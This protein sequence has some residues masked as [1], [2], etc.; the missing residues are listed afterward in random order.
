[1]TPPNAV[2]RTNNYIGRSNWSALG[3]AYANAIFD[4]LRIWS[5]S[6]TA[7]PDPGRHVPSAER[8]GIRPGGLLPV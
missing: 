1:M 3:D 2:S 6:R 4:E 7:G 5:V 8:H